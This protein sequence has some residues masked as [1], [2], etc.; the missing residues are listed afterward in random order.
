MR[1]GTKLERR[2]DTLA[3]SVKDLTPARREWG[4]SH[5]IPHYCIYRTRTRKATCVNC[6]YTWKED[7][8]KR[9]PRCGARLT[10]LPDSRRRRF[11]ERGY[12][13]IVQ[14]VEEFTLVRIFYLY[15]S[16]KLGDPK[17]SSL[18]TEV[19]QHWIGEDGTDTIRALSVAAFP[20]LRE[21]PYSF[22]SV[23]SI[24]RDSY[25]NCYHHIEP[26]AYHPRMRFSEIL[27]RN[28]FE[29]DFF[30]LYP[31]DVF[32]HLIS[33]NRFETLW[34]IGFYEMTGYYLYKGRERVV[35]YWRQIMLMHRNGASVRDIGIWFDYLE[36]LEY[37]QRDIRNPRYLFPDDLDAEHDRLMER[38]RRIEARLELERRKREEKENLAVL[39][40]K[41][42][43]FGITFGN[44]TFTVVVLKS[45]EEYR[46]E[47]DLQHHCVYTNSYYGKKD[48]L[49]LSARRR[50]APD[51]PVETIEISL[52][53]GKILQCFGACNRF[54]EYHDEIRELV[55]R[56]TY[57]Y[58]RQ[59]RN[60]NA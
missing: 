1:P 45:L 2:V 33:D 14:R 26:D 49:I 37:F 15:D 27:R 30:G 52:R 7:S 36:L 54:T 20:Y 43:Y 59:K 29:G 10:L 25:R 17:V 48:S 5:I 41:S 8:P 31:E 35:K 32:R 55:S 58:L 13:G 3:A 56:N 53:T 11:T 28:G 24:K 4:L 40:G 38:K 16:R 39:E 21:C 46:R 50:D 18:V 42:R 44:D 34:K 51:K 23:L 47:G 22:A 9:C 12:Y 19:L 6:G 57:R 60:E